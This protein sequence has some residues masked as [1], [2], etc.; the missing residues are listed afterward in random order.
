MGHR[1]GMSIQDVQL[2][3]AILSSGLAQDPTN[4]RMDEVLVVT[5]QELRS[6]GGSTN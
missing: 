6:S 5:Q 4:R 3:Q 1:C 2:S